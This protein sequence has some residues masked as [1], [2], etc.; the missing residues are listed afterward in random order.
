MNKQ[1]AMIKNGVKKHIPKDWLCELRI[2]YRLS[3]E[4]LYDIKR[5]GIVNLVIITTMAA[6]DSTDI[7]NWTERG[8][9]ADTNSSDRAYEYGAS[10][11]VSLLMTEVCAG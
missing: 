7:S 10:A 5:T 9:R 4:T 6:S 1:K 3:M 8:W 2:L 11:T